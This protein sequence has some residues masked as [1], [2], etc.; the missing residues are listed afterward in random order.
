MTIH[1]NTGKGAGADAFVEALARGRSDI[2]FFWAYFLG[3]VPHAS[4]LA[5]DE[6][7]EATVNCLATANRWG[8]T[9]LLAGRHFRRHIYKLGAE[10]TY[11]DAEGR[12]DAKAFQ[13]T[14]YRTV[15]TAGLWDTAALVWDDAHKMIRESATLRAFIKDAPLTKPPHIDFIFGSRWKFRTLGDNAEGIDG[16]SY[17]YIS[18]DEA[19]WI[20]NLQDKMDNVIKVRV[21]DVRGIID[22]VGTMKPGVSRDFYKLSAR[23]AAHTG[24]AIRFDHR[25]DTE[26]EIRVGGV[27]ATILR[28]CREF[29][30]NLDEMAEAI[31]NG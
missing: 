9:T 8:K 28:Y 29:G 24:A 17:Y 5:Y 25:D 23:A 7:A 31:A 13:K 14:K 30:I 11:L 4:Q 15:H 6:N 18:I 27:D 2:E 1:V 20:P 21:A 19:G 12:V 10:P 22:I 3:R 26:V 16:D